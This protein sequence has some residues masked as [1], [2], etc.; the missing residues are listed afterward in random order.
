MKEGEKQKLFK[1]LFIKNYSRL[2]YAA[3]YLLGDVE[4]AKDVVNDSFVNLWDEY[5]KEGND[6]DYNFNYLYLCVRN[7]CLDI[8][9][10]NEVKSKYARL[11]KQLHQEGLLAEDE[12]KDDRLDVIY[13]VLEQMPPRTRF[14][15]EQCYLENKKY[16]EVAE[17]LGLSRDGIRA[18]VMK[19]LKMLRNEFSVK[20]KKGQ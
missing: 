6:R 7:Q 19:G 9:R 14:V 5:R 18:H 10:H 1:E 15:M 16:A 8:I 17:I 4:M 11:Y 20:Y 3:L 13:K 12:Q 2:Y